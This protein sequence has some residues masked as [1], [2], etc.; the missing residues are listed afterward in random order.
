MERDQWQRIGEW[1][2]QIWEANPESRQE[3]ISTIGDTDPELQE[4]VKAFLAAGESSSL[5]DRPVGEVAVEL[6]GG[7]SPDHPEAKALGIAALGM[8]TLQEGESLGPFEIRRLLGAGGMGEVFEAL[9]TRLGRPVALKL[10][11]PWIRSP[12]A[13]ERLMREARAVSALD[14]PNI[15]TLHDIGESDDGRLYLVMS[16]YQG[17]TLDGVI[18][19]G[20]LPA[21]KA[22]EIACQVARGLARAHGAGVVH[23]DIKPANIILTEQGEAK[24]LDFGIARVAGEIALTATGGRPGTPAYMS[25]EQASG[26][27]VGPT[28][29]LWSLGVVLYEM[30]TSQRPFGGDD[31][32]AMIHGILNRSP[33]ALSTLGLDIPADLEEAVHRSL[34]KNPEDRFASAEAF[35]EALGDASPPPPAASPR[36]FPFRL[37]IST[38]A[39]L[40]T[41]WLGTQW[42]QG[43]EPNPDPSPGTEAAG[44]S[45]DEVPL[46]AVMPFANRSGQEE[47]DWYGAGVAQLVTDSL[48]HSRH[49]RV[50]SIRRIQALASFGEGD[51]EAAAE[52]DGIGFV[53]TGEILPSPEGFQLAARIISTSEQRHVGSH[54]A[55][56]PQPQLLL[57]LADEVALAARRALGT[58]PEESIDVFAADAASDNPAAYEHYLDGLRAYSDFR[59]EE[60]ETAF[61]RALEEAPDFTMALYRLAYMQAAMGRTEEA[62]AAITRAVAKAHRLPDRDQRYVRAAAAYIDRRNEEAIAVYREIIE[63][64][65][66]ETE[67]RSQLVVLLHAQGHQEEPLD[68]LETLSRLAPEDPAVWNMSGQIRF[69]LGQYQQ[70]MLDLRRYASLAPESANAHD[71]L[72][73]AYR[74]QGELALAAGE[75]RQALELDPTFRDAQ[76]DLAIVDFLQ[77]RRSEAEESLTA[78]TSDPKASPRHRIRAAF[79]LAA[80]LRSAG[81]FTASIGILEELEREISAESV[82]EAWAL[83]VRGSSEMEVDR[84]ASARRLLERAVIRSP[85]PVATRYLYTRGLLELKEQRWTDLKHTVGEIQRGALPPDDPNRGAEEKAAADLRGLQALAEGRT[86]AAIEELELAVALD[87]YS[88]RIYRLD[89]AKAYLAADQLPQALAAGR[90]ALEQQPLAEPRLDFELDRAR[91]RLL[92]ARVHEAMGDREQAALHAKTFVALWAGADP[93]LSEVTK[94]ESLADAATLE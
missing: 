57:G 75:Y 79:E 38:V 23:R 90:Q 85:T 1:L 42:W 59:Y 22:R 70:A 14:H 91:A 48:A 21:D 62:Q 84:P 16:Y 18:A 2:A 55:V 27:E 8:S 49:L 43:R 4:Q 50:A 39:L 30:L 60:A 28:S 51:L 72:G 26:S 54:G 34:A 69:S 5:L 71:T 63:Q 33:T 64:Y 35:L 32:Q 76:V 45:I 17:E 94:A 12:Q 86:T 20:S 68:L 46:I 89:L 11:P 15:C 24:I 82:R 25:P 77:G 19:R 3:L 13:K 6:L 61:G 87:G 47:L 92:L 36:T 88:Y 67:A 56:V 78:L 37:A 58:P 7:D 9:D 31:P 29:D 65:P 73:N 83:S 52:A 10:L 41:L 44:D 80:V 40:A 93:G 74:A 81:R 66:Y 53:L